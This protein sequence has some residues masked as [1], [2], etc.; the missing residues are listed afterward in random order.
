MGKHAYLI[1]AHNQVE[2]LK[3]LL[4][5]LDYIDNDIYLHLDKK[6]LS[7]NLNLIK[8]QVKFSKLYILDNR[9]DVKWGT[10]SQIECEIN[11]IK[12]A[13]KNEYQYYHLMSGV[14]L[15]LKTQSEIHKFFEDNTG[16]EFVHFDK[17]LI[18]LE[19]YKR[20]SKYNFFSSKS[21]NI[22]SK[23]AFKA[24]MFI[25]TPIDLGKKYNMIY[26]KG[27]NWFSITHE[28]SR[29]IISNE[30][31]VHKMFRYT[32]CADEIFLQTFVIN[33]KFTDKLSPDNFCD[34]YK[35]IQYCIDWKRGNPYVYR[36]C[37]Y[38][39]L[40]KSDMCFARKFDWD[41]DKDIIVRITKTVS[42]TDKII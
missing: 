18:D 15:P 14:D 26:Q 25:E 29:Y 33:S 8:E 40:L 42:L 39:S 41:I 22:F 36:D 34:N 6:W 12:E 35:T 16:T 19:V 38:D 23:I 3:S 4:T 7:C 5:C 11:L 10:Y 32:R 30:S 37:D 28:L 2:T 17:E 31:L 20:V 21:K 24:L 13:V 27:A 1:M 9:I